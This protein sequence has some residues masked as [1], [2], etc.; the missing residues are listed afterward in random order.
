M[1]YHSIFVKT[2]YNACDISRLE[3]YMF[4]HLPQIKHQG[5][6]NECLEQ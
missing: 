1:N 4:F 6:K 3:K 2:G 5:T